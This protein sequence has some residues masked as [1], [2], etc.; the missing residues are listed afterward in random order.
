MMENQN[1]QGYFFLPP[2]PSGFLCKNLQKREEQGNKFND[3]RFKL[4]ETDGV[5]TENILI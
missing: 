2:T 4:T 5:T 3:E 1:T